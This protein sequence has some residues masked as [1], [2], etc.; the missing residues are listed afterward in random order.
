M[1]SK[2]KSPAGAR[3]SDPSDQSV[4][5]VEAM[6]QNFSADPR[7]VP[8]DWRAYFQGL[9]GASA[10]GFAGPAAVEIFL[11]NPEAAVRSDAASAMI[12]A[13]RTLGHLFAR[14]NPLDTGTEKP[15]GSDGDSQSA[16]PGIPDPGAGDA[17]LRG[18]RDR[19]RDTYCRSVGAQFMHIENPEVRAWLAGRME[20]TRNRISLDREAQRGILINLTDAVIFEEFVQKKYPAA[21]TF[22]LEGSESLVP[23][24]NLAIEKAGRQNLDEIVLAMAHRGRLNVL[25]N[26]LGKN[27]RDIFQEFEDAEPDLLPGHGD[28]KYHLGHSTDRITGCGKKIHLSLC[29]NPSH[30]EFVNPVALGRL[31]A[32]QDR[33]GDSLRAKGMALL[34]HGDAAFAGEGI[35]QEILNMSGL[36]GYGVGGV[37]HVVVNNQIGFT[38]SPAEGRS[39]DYAT[40]VA[41]ML[42]IPVF[43]VNGEDPEAVAAVVE[44]AMDFRSAFSRDVIIDMFGYRRRGHNEIDEPAFTQPLLYRLIRAREPVH[45]TYL[46]SLLELG[47]VSREEAEAIA[48]NRRDQLEEFITEARKPEYKPARE[49]TDKSWKGF[50][51]GPEKN[52]DDPGTGVSADRL[53]MLMEWLTTVPDGFRLHPKIGKGLEARRR[54]GA[55]DLPLDWGAAEALAFASLAMEGIPVRLSGQD[56]QRGTFSTRHAALHDQENGD[57]YLPLQHLGKEQAPVEIHNSPLN[58]CGVLGFEYGYSL[59]CPGGLVLWEAQFGDFANAAQVIIDQFITSAEDKWNRLSGLVLLLPHGFEGMGPEHS[60]AR[61]ERFLTLAAEDNIQIVNPTTPA[62]YFHVLRRQALRRWR[63]PLVVMTP[64]SLLRLPRAASPLADL[65]TGRFRRILADDG[66]HPDQVK[67]VLL[68][69][70]K[71]YYDLAAERESLG[72]E[73]L[74]ILRLE[75]LYPLDPQVLTEALSPFR[76]GTPVTWVQEEPENMGAWRYLRNLFCD[77][78]LGRRAFHGVYRPASASPATGSASSHQLEQRQLLARAFAEGSGT[79]PNDP[80]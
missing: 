38:T 58:E 19:M 65:T 18:I 69:S 34:I 15:E 71:V 29:F 54:M 30:V 78:I 40:D 39:T 59:D 8:E 14:V 25:A 35:I 46:A 7:G 70:G 52:A 2:S 28:V 57:I 37:L 77:A 64:K 63:K 10:S 27:P 31:R 66:A 73:D 12:E 32:K 67:R 26:V 76:E 53:A 80:A 21:K 20:E 49:E 50:L 23:L 3:L 1:I 5:F 36:P 45:E 62:Q 55:G 75:Q 74:A 11:K 4:A 60:S 51:G 79:K 9:S 47:K 42:Q 16:L 48:I 41:K 22:S 43:H 17:A 33:F 24:I 61:L 72:R 68:C 44:L 6:Y 13:Y 56:S